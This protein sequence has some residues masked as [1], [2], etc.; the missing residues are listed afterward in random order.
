MKKIFHLIIC[1]F[2][3]SC[4]KNKEESKEPDQIIQE[5][6]I[7][8]ITQY[9]LT[10]TT[11]NGG[12]ISNTGGTY[13][14]GTEITI[15]ATPEEGYTFIGWDGITETSASITITLN[16]DTSLKALFEQIPEVNEYNYNQISLS[17]PPFDGT[18]FITGNI[19][20]S[21]DPSTF[22]NIEYKGTGTREMYDRRNGG[23]W[24][25]LEAYLFDTTFS[26]GLKTEIQINPEFS[27]D[28]ATTEANKYAFLIGQLSKELRKDVETVCI[29]KGEE[30]YGGGN[31]NI[32]IHTAM[33]EYYENFDTG[34][35]E[36]TLIHEATHTSIDAYHYP[37]RETDGEKWI[38]AVE[39]DGGCYIS[40]YARD[41]PY[42]EDI[43]ELFTLYVAVKYFPDRITNEL[44]DI[45]LSCCFNRI[46]FFDEQNFEMNLY[47]N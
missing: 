21:E 16:K 17:S 8:T 43:A 22:E 15:T 19:I 30:A 29:H 9:T 27:L 1:L 37:D 10:V 38:E 40:T 33:T 47:E 3:I 31:N 26:D 28:E 32:L 35:V 23:A 36:E 11:Q 7:P 46:K 44:R 20:T 5:E 45:I 42:R 18:I 12:S 24:I 41:N 25:T 34:I 13:D 39:K 6:S 4:S 2:I 14:E